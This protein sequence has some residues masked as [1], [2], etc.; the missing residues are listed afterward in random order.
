MKN[1][2]SILL[3]F[4]VNFCL[5]Q[6]TSLEISDFKKG[7]GYTTYSIY[8]LYDKAEMHDSS[9]AELDRIR[10]FLVKN[11][12]LV[13]EIGVHLDK[14]PTELYGQDLSLKRAQKIVTF[15]FNSGIAQNRLIAKGY[16]DSQP[17]STESEE[18]KSRNRRV[19]IKI[20]SQ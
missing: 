5:A 10:N 8:F 14:Q 16:G 18:G 2:F 13:V 7:E 12:S 3:F 4:G 15:L 17:F 19:V 11:S 1:I 6:T 20:L 9:Y